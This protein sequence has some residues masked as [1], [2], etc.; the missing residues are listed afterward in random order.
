MSMEEAR[1]DKST[2]FTILE[3]LVSDVPG[4]IA[5]MFCDE[6]GESIEYCGSLDTYDIKIAGA[7]S[8]IIIRQLKTAHSPDTNFVEVTCHQRTLFVQQIEHYFLVLI[9]ERRSFSGNLEDAIEKAVAKFTEE[10]G[11]KDLAEGIDQ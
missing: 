7:Y 9:L 11:L 8:A 6:E 3:T 5:S 2:F 10:A 4:A 1:E